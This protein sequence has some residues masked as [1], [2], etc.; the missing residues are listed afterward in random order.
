MRSPREDR[1]RPTPPGVGGTPILI[2]VSSMILAVFV[3]T[4]I[5]LAVEAG[6]SIAVLTAI[7]AVAVL[8]TATGLWG[9]A[10]AVKETVSQVT[11]ERAPQIRGYRLDQNSR[12][13]LRNRKEQFRLNRAWNLI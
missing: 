9:A 12:F 10:M 8:V 13:P 11:Q 2:I 7:L 4:V 3:A 6:T 1:R 5:A